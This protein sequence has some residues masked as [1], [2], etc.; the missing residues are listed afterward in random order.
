MTKK[1]A[2]TLLDEFHLAHLK[3]IGKDYRKLLPKELEIRHGYWY[4][5][6]L[7]MNDLAKL[8]NKNKN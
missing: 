6:G 5:K 4:Y 3:Y 2:Q 8:I 7:C 1:E